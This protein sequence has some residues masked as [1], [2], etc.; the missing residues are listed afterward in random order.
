MT[1]PVDADEAKRELRSLQERERDPSR[2][3]V[4]Q[5]LGDAISVGHISDASG[6]AIGR[7]IRQVVNHFELSA[8]TAAAL[9]DL[10]TVL[11]GALGLDASPYQ[12]GSLIVDRTRG[13]VGREYV[14]DAI[15]DFLSNA[16]GGYLVLRGD[17]GI[18]KSSIL[19]E[20]VRRTGCIAHFNVRSLGISTAE[21]FLQS[22]CAQLVADAG[23]AHAVLPAHATRG[24]AFLLT[25]LAEAKQQLPPG[26]PLVIAVDAL[27]EVD[28]A[29]EPDGA[30]LLFLPPVLPD[31]VYFVMTSRSIDLRL[32][33]PR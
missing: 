26:E 27:D 4:L 11:G 14:F 28:N 13:F 8:D 16:S 2:R 22:V 18:G 31:G 1:T 21:Q 12:W 33:E 20:Y 10:R 19:A 29:G 30:N 24:G 9:V 7:N 17:P 3:A 15:A 32:G 5:V 25:L 6:I 23:L